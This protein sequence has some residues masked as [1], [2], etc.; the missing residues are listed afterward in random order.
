MVCSVFLSSIACS[1]FFSYCCCRISKLMLLY[2]ISNVCRT[3]FG[4]SIL[5]GNTNIP[6]LY[7]LQDL[8]FVFSSKTI[9]ITKSCL[10]RS[11]GPFSCNCF[12]RHLSKGSVKRATRWQTYKCYLLW[13]KSRAIKSIS[14]GN[15]NRYAMSV[16]PQVSFGGSYIKSQLLS[17]FACLGENTSITG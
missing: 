3:C 10:S 1:T 8:F 16:P 14:A 15:H 11:Q 6:Y 4:L 13:F 2:R 7:R 5:I 12:R 17:L 9:L